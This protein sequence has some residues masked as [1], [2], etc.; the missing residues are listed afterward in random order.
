MGKERIDAFFEKM[1]Q[2]DA[3]E[4]RQLRD[5]FYAG[6]DSFSEEE[7]RYLQERLHERTRQ[8]LDEVS[9]SEREAEA[10]FEKK[11]RIAV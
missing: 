1:D 8:L 9:E 5:A 3:A 6:Q 11:N 2:A 4:A 10:Y 7:R